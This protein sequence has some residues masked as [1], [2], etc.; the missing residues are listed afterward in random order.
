MIDT[1]WTSGRPIPR[2]PFSVDDLFTCGVPLDQDPFILSPANWQP[3]EPERA[4]R[5]LQALLNADPSNLD[6]ELPNDCDP[7]PLALA[8]SKN[9]KRRSPLSIAI[10]AIENYEGGFPYH[11]PT[12]NYHYSSKPN[13]KVS[14]K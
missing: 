9:K 12:G 8:A 14:R 4:P 7:K 6:D 11:A 1:Y 10:H 2:I 3:G 5:L 13:E